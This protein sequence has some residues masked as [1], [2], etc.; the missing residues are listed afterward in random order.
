MGEPTQQDSKAGDGGTGPKP[1]AARPYVS[2]AGR[3]LP[4][5]RSRAAR[6]ASGGILTFLGIFGFLPIL[7][8]WMVPFGLL[9][10]SY[11]VPAV[12]RMR[13]KLE[14]WW[15]RRRQKKA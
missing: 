1:R 13:R 9:I 8:F 12:R 4:I 2:I 3:K 10:L 5:P 15:T 6:L 11:D 7:G 14:L